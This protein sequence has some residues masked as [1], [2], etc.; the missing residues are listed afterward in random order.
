VVID[1]KGALLKSSLRREASC[2]RLVLE[3]LDA[4]FDTKF[5]FVGAANEEHEQLMNQLPPDRVLE[6]RFIWNHH[7]DSAPAT[8]R[9][10]KRKPVI[11]FHSFG[12]KFRWPSTLETFQ[13]IYSA[14]KHE[15]LFYGLLKPATNPC[16]ADMFTDSQRIVYRST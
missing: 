2:P 13:T 9:S 5:Q 1:D 14:Y 11:G 16:G 4:A 15:T 12:N 10:S 3:H 7:I 8:L 6:D